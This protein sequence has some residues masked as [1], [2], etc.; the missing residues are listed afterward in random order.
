MVDSIANTV[1]RGHVRKKLAREEI[2]ASGAHGVKSRSGNLRCP[3]NG[4]A[5]PAEV[6]EV[7]GKMIVV[8]LPLTVRT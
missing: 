5:V 3:D 1:T 8:R 7:E 4:T 6:R 2:R